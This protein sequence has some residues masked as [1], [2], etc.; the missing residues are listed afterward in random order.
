MNILLLSGGLG[1]QMFQYVYAFRLKQNNNKTLLSS[2]L[3]NR[4][5]QHTGLDLNYVFNIKY[6][7]Y[8]LINILVKIIR[9]LVIFRNKKVYCHFCSL[10]LK[11]FSLMGIKLIEEDEIGK[12]MSKR[13]LNV[14]WGYMQNYKY[15][16]EIQD[17]I[18]D[19]FK[20]D[21][22]R[23]SEKS[24]SL[25]SEIK[26]RNSV[27]IHIRRGD[28]LKEENKKLF[29]NICTLNYYKNALEV[30]KNKVDNPFYFIFSDDMT[31]VKENFQIKNAFFIDWNKELDAWQDMYLMSCCKHNIIA[32]STF[33]WWGAWLNQNPQKVIISPSHFV[34]GLDPDK[35]LPNEWIK[36]FSI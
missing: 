35:I 1:N 2:Y 15:S 33:S 22:S 32:N 8:Y 27:S 19:I 17:N 3:L 20:F 11:F 26:K 23:L 5:K 7:D 28:Y 14:I 31:W 13:S 10:I 30:I 4:D 21:K 24:L 29:S 34:N 9:K 6:E 25:L 12:N 16:E 36:C 18:L